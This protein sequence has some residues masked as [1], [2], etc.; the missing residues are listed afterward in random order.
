MSVV[1]V[2]QLCSPLTVIATGYWSAGYALFVRLIG[3]PVSGLSASGIMYRSF[4]TSTGFVVLF[5]AVFYLCSVV[6]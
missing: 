5:P 6:T 4:E 3:V 1:A 2:G